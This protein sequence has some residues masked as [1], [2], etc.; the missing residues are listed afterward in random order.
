M[1]RMFEVL[2]EMNL[3]DSKNKTRMVAV[4]NIYLRAD[5]VKQG[6]KITMGADEESLMDIVSGK[7]I[8]ILVLVDKEE[9][10]KRIKQA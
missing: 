8:P 2:D 4:S 1:K 3:D 7:A 10:F 6:A 5:K 9:Y